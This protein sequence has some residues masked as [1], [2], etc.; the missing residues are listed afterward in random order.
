MT[1]NALQHILDRQEI[2]HGQ[3]GQV[4]WVDLNRVDK[5]VQIFAKDGRINFSE[6]DGNWTQGRANI[7]ALIHPLLQLCAAI[8]GREGDTSGMEPLGRRPSG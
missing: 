2:T 3:H 4:K 8:E 1:D 7:E 5:Q 6:G